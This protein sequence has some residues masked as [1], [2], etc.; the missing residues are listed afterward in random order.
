M[1]ILDHF[2]KEFLEIK[3]DGTIVE[4]YIRK[5]IVEIKKVKTLREIE[6]STS[7]LAFSGNVTSS[8]KYNKPEVLGGVINTF[9]VSD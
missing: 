3:N 2:V 8:F 6:V 4:K 1:H 9:S 7:T 5:V